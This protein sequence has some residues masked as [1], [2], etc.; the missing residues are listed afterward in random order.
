MATLNAIATAIYVN[1]AGN[2][3]KNGALSDINTINSDDTSTS[4]YSIPGDANGTSSYLTWDFTNLPANAVTVNTVSIGGTLGR[5]TTNPGSYRWAMHDTGGSAFNDGGNK[6]WSVS[7]TA[8]GPSSIL[9]QFTTAWTVSTYNGTRFGIFK[10]NNGLNTTLA[11]IT[12]NYITVDYVPGGLMVI[13]H[14]L[15]PL[16]GVLPTLAHVAGL[17]R[18]WNPRVSHTDK[19]LEDVKEELRAMQRGYVFLGA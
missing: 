11:Y 18:G 8:V 1:T 15:A 17:V 5:S 13:A 9:Y 7:W 19:E 14:G 16:I 2:F 3:T 6:A 10:V 12:Y 4:Y